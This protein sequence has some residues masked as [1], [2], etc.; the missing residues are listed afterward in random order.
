M[1]HAAHEVTA[2]NLTPVLFLQEQR[3]LGGHRPSLC[4]A[5]RQERKRM[6]SDERLDDHKVAFLVVRKVV[7]GVRPSGIRTFAVPLRRLCSSWLGRDPE[8]SCFAR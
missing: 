4:V 3:N 6:L 5:A 8:P 7:P 1:V 2:Q